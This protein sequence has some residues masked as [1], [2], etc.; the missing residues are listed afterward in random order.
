ML[1][2]LCPASFANFEELHRSDDTEKFRVIAGAHEQPHREKIRWRTGASLIYITLQAARKL[3]Y[4]SIS[5]KMKLA[6]L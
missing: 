6:A 5:P 3:P 1:T 4:E 2:T